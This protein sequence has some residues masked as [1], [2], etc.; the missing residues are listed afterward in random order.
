[1]HNDVRFFYINALK[2]LLGPVTNKLSRLLPT[3][4]RE[5]K[6]TKI[7][8]T[9]CLFLFVLYLKNSVSVGSDVEQQKRK[10]GDVKYSQ[11]W[12]GPRVGRKKRNPNEEMTKNFDNNEIQSWMDLIRK[13]PYSVILLSPGKERSFAVQ[14]CL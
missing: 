1:M 13:N 6:M 2:S 11:L 5:K 12:F 7:L 14:K 10:E 8:V 3:I 9:T 4:E